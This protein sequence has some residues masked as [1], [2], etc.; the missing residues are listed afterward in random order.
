METNGHTATLSPSQ[1]LLQRL[2]DPQTAAALE[3][4]LDRLDWLAFVVEATDGF[5]RRGEQLTDNIHD[6][7]SEVTQP[8]AATDSWAEQI[9]QLVTAVTKLAPVL[10]SPAL[11]RLI[12]AGLLERLAAPTTL[13]ALHQLLDQLPLLAFGAASI[14]GF[15]RRGEE[16]TENVAE[17][18]QEVRVFQWPLEA[19][20]L[21][22][23][24]SSVPKVIDAVTAL[25]N[26][27]LF[28]PEVVAVLVE[29]GRQL[30]GPYREAKHRP[31]Q[32]VGPWGLFKALRDPDVQRAL[33]VGLYIVKR[34]GQTFNRSEVSPPPG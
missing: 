16:L 2:D 26:A 34:Y 14:D 3:R 20:K 9:P 12:E 30:A 8:L 11:T 15:L 25:I 18:L 31:D 6:A 10:T 27:G 4:L 29:V 17:S 21:Q 24:L 23:V 13:A 5:L 28:D 32:P 22:Q 19:K 33:G 7:L 1:R